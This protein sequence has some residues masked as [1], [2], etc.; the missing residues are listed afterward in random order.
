MYEAIE[1]WREYQK[2]KQEALKELDALIDK[3]IITNGVTN[4]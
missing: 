2:Q 1:H 4:I 3:L